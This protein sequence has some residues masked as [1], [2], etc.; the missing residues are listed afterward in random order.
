M[1]ILSYIIVELE[2]QCKTLT[3]KL[4]IAERQVED[5]KNHINQ[6][7]FMA[8]NLNFRLEIKGKI[9]NPSESSFCSCCVSKAGLN[10]T[11]K[12]SHKLCMLCRIK[13]LSCG[14]CDAKED[15][16]IVFYII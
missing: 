16:G 14:V 7:D 8:E 6:K 13:D 12:C 1:F 15:Y 5:Y 2:E 9:E 10:D 11:L 4:S 3:N